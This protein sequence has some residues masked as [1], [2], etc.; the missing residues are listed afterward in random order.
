MDI[1]RKAT[2]YKQ[3]GSRERSVH[4]LAGAVARLVD[5]C[6]CMDTEMRLRFMARLLEN[7]ADNDE[8]AWVAE[9]EN[10]S[11]E[12][13]IRANPDKPE[14]AV[15]TAAAMLTNS[16]RRDQGLSDLWLYRF[17]DELFEQLI[18]ARTSSHA[19]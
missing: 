5:R 16:L 18:P 6:S 14:K 3:S 17:Y 12:A 19:A 8:R 11:L 10:F 7:F 2:D 13:V 1:V 15:A 4:M 9:S